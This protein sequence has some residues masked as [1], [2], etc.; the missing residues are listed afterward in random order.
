MRNRWS[1]CAL[2]LLATMPASAGTAAA[3]S[4]MVP[5]D[6][7]NTCTVGSPSCNT[8]AQAVAASANGDSIAI[9]AGTFAAPN[10]QVDKTLTIAGAGTAG[11]F[12]QPG[13]GAT[14]FEIRADGI[15]L[16]DLTIQNGGT[17][18]AFPIASDDT[19]L[20]RVAFSG[21]T[22]RGVEISAANVAVTNVRI[23]DAS[24]ATAGALSTLRSRRPA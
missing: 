19:E 21:Q 12:V 14:G 6:G 23:V 18:V 2:A 11:T 10:V 24:F 1:F 16:Q 5:G 9:A 4:W 22:V 7:S 13:A 3:T 8:I 20:T 17:G 15:V